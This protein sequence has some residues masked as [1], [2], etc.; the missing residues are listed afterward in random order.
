MLALPEGRCEEILV[1]PV[2]SGTARRLKRVAVGET[3]TVTA[4]GIVAKAKGL[5]R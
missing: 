4:K 3:V 2:D 1:L 5:K